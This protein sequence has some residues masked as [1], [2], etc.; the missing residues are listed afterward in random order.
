MRRTNEI[1]PI[2]R[3]LEMPTCFTF[4]EDLNNNNNNNL[5]IE[6]KKNTYYDGGKGGKVSGE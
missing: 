1:N 2:F 4:S 3:E 6:T 5:I